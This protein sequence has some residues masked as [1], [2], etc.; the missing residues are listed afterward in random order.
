[1][2]FTTL[3]L[4]LLTMCT[5]FCQKASQIDQYLDR[6][7][8]L[9]DTDKDSMLYYLDIGWSEAIKEDYQYGIGWASYIRARLDNY[10]KNHSKA[11]SLLDISL[12][13]FEKLENK[14]KIADVLNQKGTSLRY[15]S[16]F[17]ESLECYNQAKEIENELQDNE[18]IAN[19]HLNLG[20]LCN[21]QGEYDKGLDYYY[22]S[23]AYFEPKKDNAKIG[24]CYNNIAIVHYIARDLEKA[25]KFYFLTIDYCEKGGDNRTVA[26]CYQN[27][28]AVY[29][30]QEKTDSILYF[31][32]KVVGLA[33]KLAWYELEMQTV[34]SLGGIEYDKGNYDKALKYYK[35]A[36]EKFK[37]YT[38]KLESVA[39]NF[40]SQGW[41]YNKMGKHDD[42]IKV[43]NKGIELAES[44][45]IPRMLPS[46]YQ[47][48]AVALIA[49][50]KY[51]DA[52]EASIKRFESKNK[53]FNSEKEQ[54]KR[55]VE[56][57]YSVAKEAR[58][59]AE[60]EKE[61]I[62]EKQ[63]KQNFTYLSLILC[64]LLMGSIVLARMYFK[65]YR[66]L[67]D[68]KKLLE[69]ENQMLEEKEQTLSIKNAVLLKKNHELAN[70][71]QKA[72]NEL[73]QIAGGEKIDINGQTIDST[74]V[75]YTCT[76]PSKDNN[77]L[78]VMEEDKVYSIR[79]TNKELIE[80]FPSSIF[81]QINRSNIVNHYQVRHY[82][83]GKCTMSNNDTILVSSG[84]KKEFEETRK[85]LFNGNS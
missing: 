12:C 49:Q 43:L 57:Q 30:R 27:L 42:A 55:K 60:K 6:A 50:K 3:L 17:D 44:N 32:N 35:Q 19:I 26:R 5:I 67:E 81:Q 20:T 84:K 82:K 74:E 8:E 41:V 75:L 11:D 61:L 1:M 16:R 33:K 15:Q 85:K 24:K 59:T 2:K 56:A 7:N 54:I 76:D 29:S 52:Y 51:K 58:K 48:K 46:L 22:K 25:K 9:M 83:F 77:K 34:E 68:K 45:K 63:K 69:T 65:N 80:L 10:E 71:T 37:K 28:A 36:E 53:L 78:V 79:M 64:G 21:M 23:L 31:I 4:W 62:E 40:E 66:L 13:V 38:P 73:N 14:E 72:K 70:Q 39:G 18:G 47:Q